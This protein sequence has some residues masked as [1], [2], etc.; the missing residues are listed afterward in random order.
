MAGGAGT[1]LRPLTEDRP[2]PMVPI[3]NQ[4]ILEHILRLLRRHGFGSVTLTLHYRPEVIQRYF[5]SG[6]RWRMDLRYQCEQQPMGTAGGVA[7]A[8]QQGERLLVLSGDAMTDF[9]LTQM[10]AFHK[11]SRA[12]VTMALT[13]VSD[14]TGLGV[15]CTEPG[16]R[17]TRFVEK[18]SSTQAPSRTVNTGIYVLEPEVLDLIPRHEPHDFGRQLLPFLVESRA[19]VY[20]WSGGG[21]WRDVGTLDSYLDTN[22]AALRREVRMEL[23]GREVLP[24]VWCG[25]DVELHPTADVAGPALIGDRAVIGSHTVVHGCVIGADAHIGA[26]AQL[27]QCVVLP[28]QLVEPG[29]VLERCIVSSR[30]ICTL[31]RAQELVVG[32]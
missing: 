21:F 11:H 5:G 30:G 6:E 9:D 23:G 19:R 32:D 4:P 31:N 28:G 7:Q 16:G 26:A 3:A 14:T 2:K 20:G 17:V 8:A 1:R 10:L 27:H 25:G 12:L 18:P 22:L 29:A 13:E 24:M 15:V